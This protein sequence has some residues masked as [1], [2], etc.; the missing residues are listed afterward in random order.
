MGRIR[1]PL[2][3]SPIV[4]AR[5]LRRQT[6]KLLERMAPNGAPG[7]CELATGVD[8]RGLGAHAMV[9]E[10]IPD[11]S[12]EGWVLRNLEARSGDLSLDR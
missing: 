3:H 2:E 12:T 8:T 11:F 4:G 1:E 9:T 6:G 10:A 5:R 7:K